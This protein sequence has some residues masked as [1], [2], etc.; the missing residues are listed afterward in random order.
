MKRLAY[1]VV[2]AFIALIPANGFAASFKVVVN[3]AVEVD[4]LSKKAISDLFMKRTPKWSNGT[5]VV[6]VDQ[7]ER[8]PV[9]EE[10]S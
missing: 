7:S 1:L 9:R 2:I 3:S 5:A 10:F 4:A 6:P 8:A